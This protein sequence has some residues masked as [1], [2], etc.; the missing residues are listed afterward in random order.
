MGYIDAGVISCQPDSVTVDD[1]DTSGRHQ[2]HE[3]RTEC[4]IWFGNRV[5]MNFWTEFNAWVA[6]FFGYEQV[7]GVFCIL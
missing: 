7:S 6:W 5:N 1:V 4:L 2:T 3:S